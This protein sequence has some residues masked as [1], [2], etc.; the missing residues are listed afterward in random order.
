MWRAVIED[1]EFDI[2]YFTGGDLELRRE[3]ICYL[4]PD[5]W[6]N[7][8]EITPFISDTWRWRQETV[9]SMHLDYIGASVNIGILWP[10]Y[11]EYN[12]LHWFIQ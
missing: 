9:F 1:C 7:E 6:H 5:R 4:S 11:S 10:T 3:L 12:H 2:L 8:E